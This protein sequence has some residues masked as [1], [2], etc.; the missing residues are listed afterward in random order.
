MDSGTDLRAA[1]G[2]DG[3]VDRFVRALDRAPGIEVLDPHGL[4][5]RIRTYD[6]RVVEV[7]V[8]VDALAENARRAVEVKDLDGLAG[9][10]PVDRSF[11]LFF[12]HVQAA[13]TA[14]PFRPVRRF[15]YT[16]QGLVP[17]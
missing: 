17:A 5:L 10:D 1:D 12:L 11:T 15:R 8:E 13:M 16:A 3:L 9:V 4:L 2:T 6:D 14:A 7:E